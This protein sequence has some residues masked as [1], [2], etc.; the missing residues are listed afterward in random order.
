MSCRSS[1]GG[2]ATSGAATA[3][4]G[5]SAD[6]VPQVL[7]GLRREFDTAYPDAPRPTGEEAAQVVEQLA[8]QVRQA[9]ELPAWRVNRV[10]RKCEAAAAVLR[11]GRQVPNA[12]TLWAWKSLP[13]ALESLPEK[14]G[15]AE[16]NTSI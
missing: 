8:M 5:K 11:S 4:T 6:A 13:A 10:V 15:T 1:I 3:L 9:T 12:A 7:H 16:E 14:N 2:K